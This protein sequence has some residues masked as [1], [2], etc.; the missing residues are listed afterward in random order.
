M[1]FYGTQFVCTI[2]SFTESI[3]LCA[4]QKY[5]LLILFSQDD[6]VTYLAM[7]RIRNTYVTS[8]IITLQKHLEKKNILIFLRWKSIY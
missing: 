2:C 4:F 1:V 5:Y 7:F 6:A 8:Y 3:T